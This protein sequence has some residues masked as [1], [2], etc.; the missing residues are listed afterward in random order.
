LVSWL[1]YLLHILLTTAKEI[2]FCYVNVS[3]VQKLVKFFLIC[4]ILDMQNSNSIQVGFEVNGSKTFYAD[5]LQ[6]S[7]IKAKI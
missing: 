4:S 3:N 6:L 2:Y 1:N 7:R 5:G